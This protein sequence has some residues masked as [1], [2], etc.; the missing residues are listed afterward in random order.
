MNAILSN[1]AHSCGSHLE[2]SNF[3]REAGLSYPTTNKY[4]KVLNQS[5]VFFR[6]DRSL[7]EN[8][9]DQETVVGMSSWEHSG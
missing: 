8:K 7:E 6:F 2:V 3:A 5:A 1:I 4:F 9:I